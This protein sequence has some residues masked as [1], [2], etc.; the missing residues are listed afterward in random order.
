MTK[1]IKTVAIFVQSFELAGFD[2]I[3]P[4]GEYEIE[5]E[6]LDPVDDIEPG[7][8]MSHVLVHLHPRA[9]HPGLARELTV[10]LAALDLAIAK[11]K[12]TGKALGD[13]FL[14][15]MLV[16][17]MTRLVM[18]ADGVSDEEVRKFY[19]G[20]ARKA[21]VDDV[22]PRGADASTEVERR[23]GMSPLPEASRPGLPE[24]TRGE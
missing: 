16:D 21:A 3:L 5:T 7:D 17:P 24:E 8:W 19:S 20:H 11:D 1:A 23:A 9:S 13:Y 4:A 10:P 6:F 18:Q 22:V 12:L 14:E 2:E 15:E